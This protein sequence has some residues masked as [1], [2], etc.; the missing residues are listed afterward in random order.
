MLL[1]FSRFCNIMY[2]AFL[3]FLFVVVR[4]IPIDDNEGVVTLEGVKV[5]GVPFGPKDRTGHVYYGIRYGVAKRFQVDHI[6]S[7]SFTTVKRR[8]IRQ[9]IPRC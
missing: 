4:G 9:T 7:R 6:I 3:A 1:V 8:F 2:A 5:H